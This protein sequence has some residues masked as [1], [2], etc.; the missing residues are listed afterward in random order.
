MQDTVVVNSQKRNILPSSAKFYFSRVSPTHRITF[1][2]ETRTQRM[3]CIHAFHRLFQGKCYLDQKSPKREEFNHVTYSL[4]SKIPGY[5]A[6][7]ICS[8]VHSV[9]KI[10]LKIAN[11]CSP[12]HTSM[13]TL[14]I[15]KSTPH[16]HKGA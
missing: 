7:H 3:V 6:T 4:Q 16:A 2:K 14:N 10:R 13:M 5:T 8:T 1:S 12:L 11:C 15:H 9:R